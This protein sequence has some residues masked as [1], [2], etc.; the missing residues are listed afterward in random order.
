VVAR[1]SGNVALVGH[2][3]CGHG[4]VA[5]DGAEGSEVKRITSQ[6]L[7]AV[8]SLLCDEVAEGGSLVG[9]GEVPLESCRPSAGSV[10][11]PAWNLGVK[12]RV[13]ASTDDLAVGGTVRREALGALHA[14]RLIHH[15]TAAARLG[16]VT[17]V[18]TALRNV[19]VAVSIGKRDGHDAEHE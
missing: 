4:A 10:S 2:S 19:D 3:V 1:A 15:R 7:G 17:L 13:P 11:G 9:C 5:I 8:P 18:R 14:L 6:G 16:E 12:C